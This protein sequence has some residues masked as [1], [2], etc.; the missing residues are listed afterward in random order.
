MFV[1]VSV[2]HMELILIAS[3]NGVNLMSRT[4]AV[5][6]DHD[7]ERLHAVVIIANYSN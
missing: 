6:E 7:V 4:P 5:S 1:R 2:R 3:I